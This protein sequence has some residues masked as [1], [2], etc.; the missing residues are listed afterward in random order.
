[1]FFSLAVGV[2]ANE[3]I[4]LLPL[5]VAVTIYFRR[6]IHWKVWLTFAVSSIIF[7][8]PVLYW[9]EATFGAVFKTGYQ[10]QVA[11]VVSAAAEPQ[12]ASLSAGIVRLRQIKSYVLPLGL[13]FK[14]AR[15][16][17]F[18]Y[19]VK[20]FWWLSLPTAWV[21]VWLIKNWR[22]HDRNFKFYLVSGLALI[23][24]LMVYYGS[25]QY[26]DT[27]LQTATIGTSY[28]RYLLPSF[29]WLIPLIDAVIIT[30]RTDKIFFP[31]RRV[32]HYTPPDYSYLKDVAQL[33]TKAPVYFFTMLPADQVEVLNGREAGE[34]GLKLEKVNRVSNFDLYRIKLL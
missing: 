1:A 11:Q 26:N 22:K 31:G 7:I 25:H 2:R 8:T 27:T 28:I 23:C 12:V 17:G 6:V 13:N 14:L 34:A 24:W 29:L 15:Q 18:D 20:F 33:L 16:N 32:I 4:W 19:L 30:Y 9:Q 21:M 3:I 10:S 5:I